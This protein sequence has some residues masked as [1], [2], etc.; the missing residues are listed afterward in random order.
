MLNPTDFVTQNLAKL[1]FYFLEVE[2][3]I[4]IGEF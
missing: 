3:G 4:G 2:N 1:D